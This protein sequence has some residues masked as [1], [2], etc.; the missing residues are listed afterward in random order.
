M[1]ISDDLPPP[2]IPDVQYAFKGLGDDVLG[3]P[4][5]HN[6][7]ELQPAGNVLRHPGMHDGKGYRIG[8]VVK[9]LP[10]LTAAECSP[11]GK[12]FRCGTTVAAAVRRD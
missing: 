5:L 1:T 8:P 7:H 3:L 6:G 10:P 4:A 12:R 11:P 2:R 9:S